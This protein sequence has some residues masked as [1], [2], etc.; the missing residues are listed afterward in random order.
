MPTVNNPESEGEASIALGL[1]SSV[2]RDGTQSQRRLASE[3]GVALG[4]VNAYLKRAIS[5]GYVKVQEAPARRY[6]YYLTAK[7][8][9]E[10]ARLTANFFSSSFG[11]FRQAKSDC[12]EVFELARLAG[13][14]RIALLG[15][16]DLAEIVLICA[17]DSG[18]D[19]VA[20]VDPTCEAERYIGVPV[21]QSIEAV[22]GQCDAVLLTDLTDPYGTYMSALKQMDRARVLVP[23]LLRDSLAAS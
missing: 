10:K 18:I 9:S 6:S 7:G 22:A 17:I 16:S 19:I 8:F 3:L 1:L 4:L 23:C 21:A 11:F 15:K 5:K 13:F 14:C 12:A 2:G 20:V